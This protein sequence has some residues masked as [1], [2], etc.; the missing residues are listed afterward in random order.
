MRATFSGIIPPLLTPLTEDG[1]LDRAGLERLIGHVIDGGVQGLFVLGT[2]GEAPGLSYALRRELIQ[3][4]CRLTAGRVPVLVGVA[5][6]AAQ[7]SIALA[8]H[9]AECGAAAAVLAQPYYFPAGQPELLEYLQQ[10]VPQ[11][12]LPVLL[13]NMPAMTKLYYEPQTVRAAMEIANLAGLKDSSGNMLYFHRLLGE[14]AGRPDFTL[15]MG[16]EELLAESVLMG[17]DGGICGGANLFPGLYVAL[18]Q[19]ARAGDLQRVRQL[20][21]KVM[22]ISGALYGIGRFSSSYLKG[23]KAAAALLGLCGDRMA[24][25][26]HCFREPEQAE[27][28]RKL[29]ELVAD[30]TTVA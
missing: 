29:Q 12:P 26:L 10:T 11:M 22:R 2:T 4:S 18:W 15:L 16:P 7:E 21:A 6:T 8:R 23:V 24:L 5:D 13:Y 19:A 3:E 17:G 1:E 30:G 9:A 14:R 27:V 28:A 20:Q 25:P